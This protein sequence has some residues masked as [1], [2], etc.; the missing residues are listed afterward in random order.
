MNIDSDDHYPTVD[1]ISFCDIIRA[2]GRVISE[3]KVGSTIAF[4]LSG[5]KSVTRRTITI[6]AVG[7]FCFDYDF[8]TGI[9]IKHGLMGSLLDWFEKNKNWKDGGY[10]SNS[11][12][13]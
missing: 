2:S 1:A 13:A 12:K 4:I 10:I 9:A 5:S 7:D 6:R 3:R 11:I 8:A